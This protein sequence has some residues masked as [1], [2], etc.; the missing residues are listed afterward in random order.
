AKKAKIAGLRPGPGQGWG[1]ATIRDKM[2]HCLHEIF[3]LPV[4]PGTLP[5]QQHKPRF[6]NG[7]SVCLPPKRHEL[8][9]WRA[10]LATVR[11]YASDDDGSGTMA[12]TSQT[13]A[14]TT[15]LPGANA[16][17]DT[18]SSDGPSLEVW[19]SPEPR[20]TSGLTSSR[21]TTDPSEIPAAR[22]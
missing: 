18:P 22:Q 19:L 16:R 10:R 9:P 12:N 2:G 1:M 3:I 8:P 14:P 17:S 15:M 4:R 13:A 11:I 21:H 7:R 20:K 6:S 5:T